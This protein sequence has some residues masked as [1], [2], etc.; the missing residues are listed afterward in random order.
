MVT[1]DVCLF[2][3]CTNTLLNN[4]TCV[5]VS[6]E[7]VRGTSIREQSRTHVWLIRRVYVLYTRL[8]SYLENRESLET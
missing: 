8:Q 1:I 7:N 4:N 2:F 5:L 6:D 3:F